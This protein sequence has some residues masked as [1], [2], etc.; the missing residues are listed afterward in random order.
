[1][2]SQNQITAAPPA[3]A[4]DD[5]RPRGRRALKKLAARRSQT[6]QYAV[7]A[8]TRMSADVGGQAEDGRCRPATR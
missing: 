5:E 2:R 4:E 6:R 1:M 3:H 8:G 7:Q